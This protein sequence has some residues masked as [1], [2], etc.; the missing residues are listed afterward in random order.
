MYMTSN[1]NINLIF[2]YN[3]KQHWLFQSMDNEF[4]VPLKNSWDIHPFSFVNESKSFVLLAE[5]SR[6]TLI[7]ELKSIIGVLF[8]TNPK[9]PQTMM[10]VK[11]FILMALKTIKGSQGEQQV[12]ISSFIH[13]QKETTVDEILKQ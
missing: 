6:G 1:N 3:A 11:N 5:C 9:Y 10:P 13:I 7:I 2:F 4:I 12:T 8:A